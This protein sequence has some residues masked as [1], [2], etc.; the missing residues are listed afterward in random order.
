MTKDMVGSS[1]TTLHW[2]VIKKKYIYIYIIYYI[3]I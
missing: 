3:I 2:L 1:T